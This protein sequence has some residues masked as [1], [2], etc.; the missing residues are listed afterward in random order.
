MHNFYLGLVL[1]SIANLVNDFILVYFFLM[2][3]ARPI[4]WLI[5]GDQTWVE[6]CFVVG[7]SQVEVE[8]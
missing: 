7:A 8:L 4:M 3:V 5:I 1:S 6:G 2:F